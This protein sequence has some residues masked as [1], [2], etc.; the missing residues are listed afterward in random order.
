MRKLL[1]KD[2]GPIRNDEGIELVI[3]P[4]TVLI[5]EQGT[6]KSTIVK[7]ISEFTWLEKSIERGVFSKKQVVQYNRFKKIHC[8]Y[9][10][11]QNY[12]T[13]NT[14][15]RFI[16]DKYLFEYKDGH[17]TIDDN[18]E[19]GYLRPQV[20]YFPAER[21]LVSA[22]E[23]AD[24]IKRL[25]GSVA[26]LLDEYNR[27]LRNAKDGIMPLPID[28][29]SIQYDKLNRVTWLNGKGVKIRTQES[30]SGFQSLIPLSVV[31]SYLDAYVR[32][33]ST[34]GFVED[35]AEERQRLEKVIQTLLKDK[36]LDDSIKAA[37][38][39]ELS[40]KKRNKRFI[41]VVEEPEQNLFPISQKY[42]LYELLSIKNSLPQNELV[43]TTHSPYLIN[44]LSLAIK[45][46]NVQNHISAQKRQSLDSIVPE[47]ARVSGDD[48]S[49]YITSSNGS[50]SVLG[51]YDGM[52][53]DDNTLNLLLDENNFLYDKILD[54]E[55]DRNEI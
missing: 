17:L 47:A 7:L 50:I 51:K 16:G 40:E 6:G 31:S 11:I 48:V 37:L 21:N 45:A 22:I 29:F 8:T 46:F 2:F 52:P 39:K 1:V 27:A 26:T 55:S 32:K 3:S 24:K 49:V 20:M 28:G 12:F 5:G 35:S 9:H 54:L 4:V 53:S 25:P 33:N 42:V 34:D 14:Y 19:G 18:K 10:G 30:A 23:S 13:N 15:I 36:T 43:F 41:N 38:L 44:Y